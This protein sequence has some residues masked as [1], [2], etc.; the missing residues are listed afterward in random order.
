MTNATDKFYLRLVRY[1]FLNEG[2]NI[3]TKRNNQNYLR[4]KFKNKVSETV[5]KKLE[6]YP[7]LNLTKDQLNKIKLILREE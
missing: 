2:S 5:L 3:M 4:V 7:F 6:T 1:K